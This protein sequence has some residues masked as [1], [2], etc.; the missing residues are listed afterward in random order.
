M[1]E[2]ITV[3][4]HAGGWALKH[5]GGFIGLTRSRDQALRAAADLSLWMQ[6][7]GRRVW[8]VEEEPLSFRRS[9]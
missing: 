3:A 4:P 8:I 7:G 2:T 5:A 9:A 1:T 6:D